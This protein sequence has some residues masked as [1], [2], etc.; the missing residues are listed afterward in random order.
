M[1]QITLAKDL[2]KL[3]GIFSVRKV[4]Y[5]AI[6]EASE[7]WTRPIHDWKAAMNR[8]IIESAERVTD[9]L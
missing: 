7:K 3:P 2:N 6:R 4:V 8:P 1:L 9:Y 5:S